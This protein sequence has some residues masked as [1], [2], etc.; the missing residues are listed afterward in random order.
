M[1]RDEDD[2]PVANLEYALR[3]RRFSMNGTVMAASGLP[4]KPDFLS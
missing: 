3:H 4:S 2:V 1:H